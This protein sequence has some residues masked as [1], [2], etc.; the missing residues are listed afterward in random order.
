[1]IRTL[2][3]FAL[4]LLVPLPA[5][6]S[7][8]IPSRDVD[9]ELQAPDG[10]ILRGIVSIPDPEGGVPEGTRWP[11][12]VLLPGRMRERDTLLPL[13]DALTRA[14]IAAV[15]VD[16]RG[17]GKSR[18]TVQ[19]QMYLGDVMP[20]T[21]LR[22]A[23]SDQRLVLD[24]LEEISGLDLSR[25]AFVGV[26]EGALVAADAAAGLPAARALVM[27]DPADAMGGLDPQRD[28]GLFDRRP[29]LL[30]C[31]GFPVSKERA[32][33]FAEYGLGRRDVTCV[34]DFQN[35]DAL[36]RTGSPATP[37]IT[38]W[39]VDAIGAAAPAGAAPGAGPP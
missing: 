21:Y 26:M 10:V 4:L 25:L 13:A 1:M 8:V 16:P 15:L 30:L 32:R 23:A 14:G 24:A 12:A 33:L 29:V 3:L 7:A 9:L 31:S 38:A 6:A 20:P 34:P 18:A 19:Q 39:L 17:Q 36:L 22:A 28:L 5:A 27:V 35:G 11:V 2:L 37:A